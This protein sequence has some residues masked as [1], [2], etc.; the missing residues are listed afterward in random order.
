MP[1]DAPASLDEAELRDGSPLCLECGLCCHGVLH[2]YAALEEA[3]VMKAIE[4][5]LVVEREKDYLGFVLPCAKIDV[6]RCTVYEHRLSTCSGYQCGLLRRYRR[7]EVSLGEALPLIAK[8]RE[9]FDA[10]MRS[11]PPTTSFRQVREKWRIRSRRGTSD[12]LPEGDRE[13]LGQPFVRIV[14]LDLFLDR[15]FRLERERSYAAEGEGKDRAPLGA[16][17]AD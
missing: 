5:G 17:K 4:I 13:E 11:V 6:T 15:F 10:V 14:M 1:I 12:A 2:H 7:G 9:L 8:A 16:E 3:E